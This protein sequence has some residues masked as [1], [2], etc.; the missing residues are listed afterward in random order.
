M[1]H[2]HFE[3][4]E[5]RAVLENLSKLRDIIVKA[6]VFYPISV[7]MIPSFQYISNVNQSE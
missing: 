2:S 3:G 7:T 5:E 6:A 1:A 4:G